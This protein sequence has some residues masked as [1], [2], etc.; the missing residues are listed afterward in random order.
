MNNNFKILSII[1]TRPEAIKM[2][3]VIN[4]LNQDKDIEHKICISVV[5]FLCLKI[6]IMNEQLLYR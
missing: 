3:P 2:Y 1:G 6:Q 4:L 5:V